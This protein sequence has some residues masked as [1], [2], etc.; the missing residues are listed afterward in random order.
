MVFA[1]KLLC[2][3]I[4]AY[5]G[6]DKFYNVIVFSPKFFIINIVSITVFTVVSIMV[7]IL[8]IR[9]IKPLKIIKTRN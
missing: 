5:I 9:K 7:P 2:G 1:N 6:Q 3:G 4:S 8:A